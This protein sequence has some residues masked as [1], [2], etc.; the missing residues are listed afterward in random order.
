MSDLEG[1]ID[2]LGE[3]DVEVIW[4]MD[5]PCASLWLDKYRLLVIAASHPGEESV[6]ACRHAL[7]E[8]GGVTA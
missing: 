8:V 2:R 6:R 7:L 4:A 5:L 3:N 1:L